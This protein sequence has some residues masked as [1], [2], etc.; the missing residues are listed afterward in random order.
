MGD[1]EGVELGEWM[2]AAVEAGLELGEDATSRVVEGVGAVIGFGG[3]G[4]LFSLGLRFVGCRFVV[5]GRCVVNRFG[6]V[7]VIGRLVD[8]AAA[9]RRK[10]RKDQQ[11]PYPRSCLHRSH[12]EPPW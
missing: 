2:I 4:V 1:T 8:L 6:L 12:C 3:A 7:A 5:F 11:Q 9:C 10:Q